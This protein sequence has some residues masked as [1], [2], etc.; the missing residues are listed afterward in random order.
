MS[1]SQS[2]QDFHINPKIIRL[3]NKSQKFSMKPNSKDPQISESTIHNL[4]LKT[5]VKSMRNQK[6]LI[7]TFKDWLLKKKILLS[8]PRK[9]IL[10]FS[11]KKMKIK[12]GIWFQTEVLIQKNSSITRKST[13]RLS[14][15]MTNGWIN[16]F[17]N[18]IKIRYWVKRF[19]KWMMRMQSLH[20][21]VP[22]YWN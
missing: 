13:L 14:N 22:K 7:T 11:S 5:R 10:K 6:S 1:I 17:K 19:W 12:I 8:V 9:K 4:F 21:R 16:S 18:P 20:L 2:I 15:K 3:F